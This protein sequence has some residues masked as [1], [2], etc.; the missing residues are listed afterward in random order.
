LL[1]SYGCPEIGIDGCPEI[2]IDGCP[3]IGIDKLWLP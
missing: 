1:I 3:E 2:G